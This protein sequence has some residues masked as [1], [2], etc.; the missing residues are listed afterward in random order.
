MCPSRTV[1][2]GGGWQTTA[3]LSPPALDGSRPTSNG[4]GWEVTVTNVNGSSGSIT[5]YAVCLKGVAGS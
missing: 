4:K 2:V 5:A 1:A 3:E